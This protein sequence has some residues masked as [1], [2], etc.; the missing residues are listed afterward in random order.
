[1]AFKM[2]GFSYPGTSPAKM[3]KDSSMKMMKKSPTKKTYKEA[4]A[5]RGKKYQDMDEE[6][7]IKEAKN[8]NRKKYLDRDI[9]KKID[10]DGYVSKDGKMKTVAQST[11]DSPTGSKEYNELQ[12]KLRK[13]RKAEVAAQAKKDATGVDKKRNEAYKKSKAVKKETKTNPKKQTNL[14]PVAEKKVKVSDKK[15]IGPKNRVT[16]KSAKNSKKK[17][18]TDAR[19]KS[20]D[21]DRKTN[22]KL[23]RK[24]VK[25]AR[26]SGREAVK[27][28]RATKR[29]VKKTVK[30]NKRKDKKEVKQAIKNAKKAARAD[31][32]DAKISKSKRP[33]SRRNLRKADKANRLRGFV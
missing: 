2:K 26:K 22:R 20:Y 11:A 6:T 25:D 32:L 18:I 1:M 19:Q 12:K 14:G 23:K 3:K 10:K 30:A 27:E 29:L 13:R 16:V 24:A 9:G 15:T 17:A 5:T 21:P 28:A 33:N 31:K 7:Y 4:Y 8:Y